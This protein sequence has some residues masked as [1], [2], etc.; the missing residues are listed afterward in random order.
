MT[1]RPD[2]IQNLQPVL[3]WTVQTLKKCYKNGGRFAIRAPTSEGWHAA[4]GPG[5]RKIDF[6]RAEMKKVYP[7]G[8]AP[9]S[10]APGARSSVLLSSVFGPYAQNDEY[11]SRAMNPMELYHKENS[12]DLRTDGPTSQPPFTRKTPKPLNGDVPAAQLSKAGYPRYNG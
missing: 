3:F 9:E 7:K 5:C 12:K 2:G 10:S 8:K 4:R 1:L 6:S 11:G